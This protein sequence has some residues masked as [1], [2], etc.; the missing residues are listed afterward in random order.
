MG[1]IKDDS[2]FITILLE[3]AVVPPLLELVSYSAQE[4]SR[5]KGEEV[6]IDVT[7][8]NIG[9]DCKY[10]IKLVD[11]QGSDQGLC[12]VSAPNEIIDEN[13]NTYIGE[14]E[15]PNQIVGDTIRT[16]ETKTREV[17]TVGWCGAMPD[18]SPAGTPIIAGGSWPLRVEVWHEI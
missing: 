10:K 7:I 6:R 1:E 4:P 9:G 12:G 15:P 17:N 11:H 3:E 2:K 13:P 16:G 5:K 8:K 18:E 14:G